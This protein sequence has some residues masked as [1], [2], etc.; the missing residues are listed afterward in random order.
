MAE[1]PLSNVVIGDSPAMREVMHIV[2]QVARYPYTTVLLQGESGTGKEV[3]AHAI[4]ELSRRSTST[5]VALNCAAIPETLLETELFGVEAGAFTDARVSRP[6]LLTVANKG[7]LFLDE[8]ASMPLAL[9]AKLLRFLETRSFVPV[10][11]TKE[12]HVELRIIS[13]TNVDLRVAISRN[14]F[15][16]DLFYRLKVVP[17]LIPP[18]RDRSEDIDPLISFFLRSVNELRKKPLCISEEARAMLCEYLWPGNVRELRS[19]IEYV[20][21]LCDSDL[22]QPVHLPEN[23]R[24]APTIA[25]HRLQELLHQL[26][27]PPEGVNLQG[28]LRTIEATF[29]RE[30]LAY[31][32][33]NQVHA[34][35]LLHISRDQLR[36]RLQLLENK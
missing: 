21:I 4:H 32:H 17:I 29:V 5:F 2:R 34:A 35:A 26:H 25:A 19:V 30:A 15:R 3:I 9:Q 23:I 6:G 27:L 10:G 20:S 31:S 12:V 22:V 28:F 13:A 14:A 18:L 8:I 33:G 1:G 7:T 16:E 36:Y 24:K 11:S